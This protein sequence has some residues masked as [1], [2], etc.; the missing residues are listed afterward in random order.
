M[1]HVPTL[2]KI[3]GLNFTAIDFETANNER[4]SACALGIVKVVDGQIHDARQWFIRPEPLEVGFYQF[5]VH[6]ISLKALENQPTFPELWSE[7]RPLLENELLVAHNLSFDLGILRYSCRHFGMTY[8]PGKA[9]CTLRAAKAN[10]KNEASYSLSKLAARLG[11][12]FKHHDALEDALACAL[13]AREM[14]VENQVNDILA[15]PPYSIIPNRIRRKSPLESAIT[16]LPESRA[17]LDKNI[18][19]TGNLRKLSREDAYCLAEHLGAV[20]SN[21]VNAATHYLVTG[22]ATIK[23]YG[24][25]FRLTKLQ[26]AQQLISLGHKIEI[27][28]ESDFYALVGL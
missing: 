8:Q 27:I 9:F 18:V 24:K 15:C 13:L 16:D 2:E 11:H 1:Q 4:S 12:T 6:G 22:D 17:I 21:S 14:A 25:K 5:R 10:W 3:P 20:P 26:E 28:S 7:I 23:R 19:F